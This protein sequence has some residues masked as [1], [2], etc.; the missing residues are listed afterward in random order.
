MK[1]SGH[2]VALPQKHHP[3]LFRHVGVARR[4]CEPRP[5]H[6]AGHTDSSE[7][8]DVRRGEM[9]IEKQIAGSED[10]STDA[11]AKGL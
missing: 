10:Q 3:C 9:A 7:W 4:A 8:R 6:L 1:R 2:G 11:I 5:E